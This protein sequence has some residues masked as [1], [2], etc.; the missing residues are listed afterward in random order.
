MLP[1]DF[2]LQSSHIQELSNRDAIAAFFAALGYNTDTRLP[3]THAAMGFTGES[4]AHDITHIERIAD[5]EQGELQV[6][7]L[8]MKRVTVALTQAIARALRNRAGNFFLVLTSDY[9]RLDFVLMELTAPESKQ[10][11]FNARQAYLRPRLLTVN[12][13]DPGTVALRVLR[14]FS[15]TEIDPLYQWDKLR[16]AYG[17][18]EWS[19]PFFDNRG[20]FADYYLNERLKDAPEWQENPAPTLREFQKLF[21]DVRQRVARQ[22]EAVVRTQLIEPALKA[23][24]FAFKHGKASDSDGSEPDYYFYAGNDQSKP[25][26]FCDAYVWDRNLDGRDETRDAK[27]PDEIPGQLVVSLLARDDAPDWVITTNGKTWRL[28]SARSHS[29]ATNYYEIDLEEAIASPDPQFAFRYFWVMFRST[30]FVGQDGSA[31]FLTRL[32][33]ESAL[34]AKDLGERLKDRIFEEIFPHFADGFIAD[35]R[36]RDGRNADLSD[37]RLSEIFHGTLTFLYR[38]LFL[39]YAEARD[40]LPAREERGYYEISFTRLKKEIAERAQN[41]SDDAP[42][43]IEKAYG[44]TSTELYDRL[45]RLFAVIDH[46]EASLNVPTYNGGLFITAPEP[47]DATPEAANARFLAAHKIPDRYLARGLDL[48]ARDLDAKTHALAMIDYKSLGVRQLGSIYEGLLEFKLRVASEKMAIVKGKKT[49]EI[50]PYRELGDRR[51]KDSIP[52]GK[53]YLE[54]D[55]RERKATGSYY[56]PDYI[57]KYIVQHTVGPVLD[58]KCETLRPKLRE[59]Q[60]AYRDAVNRQKAFQKQGMTGDNP[61]KV[62]DTFRGLVDELFDLRVLDPAMGSGHFLVEAVDFITD[63]M[64]NFLNAFPWNPIAAALRTTRETILAQM[65]EQGV[66]VNPARLTDV[67]LLKRHVLKRCV[68]GV[69]LNPMAVELAKVSLWLD[70]FTLGAPLSFLD[71]H[72]KPGNSLIGARIAEVRQAIDLAA[73]KDRADIPMLAGLMGSEFAGVMLAVDLMRRV[74][75]LSDVTAA[76]VKESRT[77]FRRAS[78]ALAPYKRILDVYT[79]RWFGNTDTKLA[80]PAIQFLRDETHRAWLRDPQRAHDALKKADQIIADTT[81]T[82]AADKKFFHWELEFPEVFFGPS[83]ASA[84]EIVLKENAGFDAVVGNPPYDVLAEKERAED[85]SDVSSFIASSP[86]LKPA[87]GRKVD[88]YRLFLAQGSTLARSNGMFGL[89]VPMS[90]LGDQQP[91][92]VRLHLL[93]NFTFARLDAFP[94]KDDPARRIFYEAKL[95]TCIPIIRCAPNASESFLLTIHPGN[96][97]GQ[98]EGQSHIDYKR[99]QEIIKSIGAIPLTTNDAEFNLL[100]R[101]YLN[102]AFELIGKQLVTY[103]GEMNETTQIDYLSEEQVGP[104]VYRG[105]N[106]QRY[107]FLEE[108]RQGRDLYVKERSFRAKFK[109]GKFQHISLKRY[110]YQRKAALDNWRRLIFGPLPQPSYCFDSVSYF[111]DEGTKS[112]FL[113]AVLNSR[114]M[115][116]RFGLTSTNNTVSTD[117]IASLPFRRIHF[118]TPAAQ[119]KTR[120]AALVARYE[121]KADAELLAEVERCLPKDADGAFLAFKPGATGAEEQSDVVHDLL[122]YFAEQMIALNKKKQAEQ[123][124]FLGWLEGALTIKSD[125]D[126]NTGIDALVGKSRLRAYLGDYQKDE[127]ELAFDE[128]EDILFKNR[129]RLGASLSEA[130]FA[131]RLHTEYDKSLGILLPIKAQLART[132]AL[133]D[134]IVYRL[135]GLTDGEITIVEGVKQARSEVQVSP[136]RAENGRPESIARE[137]DPRVMAEVLEELLRLGS[138]TTKQLSD[139]LRSRIGVRLTL[140]EIGS[141]ERGTK[142]APDKAETIK[143]EF[144]FLGWIDRAEKQWML[145]EE[146]KAI[147]ERHLTSSPTEF[148]RQLCIANDLRNQRVVSRLLVRLWEL[149]PAHQGAV[150]VPLPPVDNAPSA[151]DEVRDWLLPLMPKW[152]D[153][154]EKQMPG[155]SAR[156]L[157][158]ELVSKAMDSLS[159]RWAKMKPNEQRK[160]LQEVIGERFVDLMFSHIISPADV[161]IWQG[162]LDWA[163]LTLTAR[164]LPGVAGRVWFPVGAFREDAS[165]DFTSIAGLENQGRTYF[166]YTPSGPEFEKRFGEVLYE[167]YAQRQRLEQVEY[168]S[169]LAVRDYVCYRLRIGNPHFEKQLQQMFPKAVRSELPYSMALEVDV[170]PEERHRM[171]GALPIVVDGTPRYIIA[172]RRK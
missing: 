14:R 111:L 168:V 161:E 131:S 8:E 144:G 160:R 139:S 137:S 32:L 126:G 28:Y 94:Q 167:A 77:E 154:L 17:I 118:T 46:G 26:A 78:D 73:Q 112:S 107:D 67:N 120:V 34:Y 82:A 62:A 3:M 33:D 106:V 81:L 114:L 35:L 141:S 127:P 38:L 47:D 65:Q 84:Q 15:Y 43:R 7:L 4:L 85:L 163:G 13:R 104:L 27:T 72:L 10:T 66:S 166:C 71:H 140:S 5:H 119:R 132:D 69:D 60:K 135:Y 96:L 151:L 125:K 44:A 68:Y 142:L 58:E 90:L 134:K 109:E 11:G 172:M 92:N 113:L 1:H 56:T 129:T 130:R 64:L 41:I 121:R 29:R 86:N 117:E 99:L 55:K 6:Y 63:R 115:E 25:I 170:T 95:A 98:V 91:E 49:D 164:D 9:E 158:E 136:R 61:D 169:L 122:A 150:I 50:I 70:C 83:K 149:N 48:M 128:L 101:L 159:S 157:P 146:G 16:S 59:A 147:A 57:V 30:A 21:A 153:G 123:K 133:V 31:S 52:K 156:I 36:A 152:L 42:A 97:L 51:A 148:A 87:L 2:D 116:W 89:I 100:S 145:T 75:E 37:E 76:Q 105:G 124:R 88:L 110:G 108:A 18:A 171:K 74:G 45:T 20:L 103:Q 22:D 143:R 79:S 54:N 19:E 155:L 102:S 138:V 93:N 80:Q 23:L 53:P 165:G 39:L 162:R 12:R 24:G 40:L